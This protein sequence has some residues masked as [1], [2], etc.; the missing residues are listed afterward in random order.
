MQM[1]LVAIGSAGDINPFIVIGS[2]LKKMGH[3]VLLIASPHFEDK[4]HRA[5]L[6]LLPLGTEADYQR[7]LR[8]PDVWKASKGFAAVWKEMPKSMQLT[9]E[10]IRKHHKGNNTRLIG[11]T[12]AFGARLAQEKFGLKL[13]TIH[14]APACILSCH[15]TPVSMTHPLPPWFPLWLKRLFYQ[16]MDAAVLDRVSTKDF[17]QYRAELDLPPTK[18]IV[19]KYIHS[20]DLV[21]GAFPDWFAQIQ[22]DWPANSYTTGFPL[23]TGEM[24]RPFSAKLEQFFAN[25][26]PPV[27]FT[28]GSA[29]AF[30]RNYFERAVEIIQKSGRRGILVS[31]FPDQIPPNLPQDVIHIEYANF[32]EL[33]LRAATVVHHGGIGTSA[34]ALA[35]GCPQVVVPYAHDQ[36][37]NGLRMQGLGVGKVQPSINANVSTWQNTFAELQ[38]ARIK[39]AC[40]RYQKKI[41]DAKPAEQQIAEL[42]LD[43]LS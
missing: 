38:D 43:K 20:P 4:A 7:A 2:Y 41:L 25:G 24:D 8:N 42:V 36:F 40:V 16:I 19:S 6:E 39:D 1:I 15:G 14:L 12:L 3:E 10:L 21:I 22:T 37:D 17:N 33:F 5:G 18:N 27:V 26:A 31:S 29:M 34:M 11:S 30:S 28:A 35:S 9:Y 32:N 13:A 23:Y